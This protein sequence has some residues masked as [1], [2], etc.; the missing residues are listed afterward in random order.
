MATH[1]LS[2]LVENIP[3]VLMRVASLFSRRG[4]NIETLAVGPAE[5]PEL[6]RMTVVVNLDDDMSLEQVVKQ[7]HKLINVLKI[8][9]LQPETSVA[10]E[11]MLVKVHAT[12]EQ[13][14][15]VREVVEIFRGRI[16]DMNQESLTV[17]CTGAPDKLMALVANLRP[18][19]VLELAQT[20]RVGLE[21]SGNG[22]GKH[23]EN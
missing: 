22:N 4:Y 17:E 5:R 6:S 23:K 11:L 13:R 3:G 7:C 12:P 19:G 14:G 16:L 1:T 8:T 20:G 18:F 10:R 9:E 21:R 2:L 15:Q